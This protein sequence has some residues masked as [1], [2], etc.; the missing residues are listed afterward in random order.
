MN[1]NMNQFAKDLQR[2]LSEAAGVGVGVYE[3]EAPRDANGVVLFDRMPFVVYTADPRAPEDEAEEWHA[4]LFVD[5]W[6][7]NGWDEC[8]RTMQLLDDALDQRIYQADGWLICIDRNGLC[9]QRGERD[10]EDERL[11]RM[12]GQYLIRFNPIIEE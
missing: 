1:C 11:R 8:Y 3:R 10:P 5:V 12:S 2:I 7:R 4:D 6:A 9:F